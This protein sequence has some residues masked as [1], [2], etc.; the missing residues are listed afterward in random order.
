MLSSKRPFRAAEARLRVVEEKLRAGTWIFDFETGEAIWS[1]GLFKLFGLDPAAVVPTLD[2]FKSLIHPDD[3]LVHAS[4]SEMAND[5]RVRDR[6]FRLI[7]PDGRLLHVHN[8]AEPHFDRTGRLLLLFGTAIDVTAAEQ[9]RS[10]L[11]IQ[12]QITDVLRQRAAT[13]VW[14]ADRDGKLRDLEHWSRLT[15]QSM[16]EARDWDRL[17]AIH[18]DDRVHFREAWRR[19]IDNGREFRAQIRV[20]LTSGTYVG[21]SARGLPVRDEAGEVSEW[22]GLSDIKSLTGA[23]EAQIQPA[24]IRAARALLE[25]SGPELAER[26]GISFSTLRRMEKSVTSV[27]ADKVT[28]V[29]NALAEHGVSFQHDDTGKI[30]VTLAQDF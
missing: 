22:I 23:S 10:E 19:A 14:R 11:Q 8:R 2:L 4:F 20:K 28:K 30:G 25:W 21:V 26:S 18:P 16:E 3:R 27:Q 9:A 29:R 24:Q 5:A 17:A 13:S 15:G 1:D 7:R 12:Q 6:T